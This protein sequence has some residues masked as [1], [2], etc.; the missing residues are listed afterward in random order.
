MKPVKTDNAVMNTY[1]IGTAEFTSLTNDAGGNCLFLSIAQLIE[2]E[3][4]REQS[5]TLI[6]SNVVTHLAAIRLSTPTPAREP[7]SNGALNMSQY[8]GD[9][10]PM[11]RNT[12]IEYLQRAL[13]FHRMAWE[14]E[15]YVSL[16]AYQKGMAISG[17][18]GDFISLALLSHLYQKRIHVLV[19][20]P[21]TSYVLEVQNT[22]TPQGQDWYLVNYANA[23]F[24]ALILKS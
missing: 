20:L 14:E 1:Q 11:E 17:V 13:E 12:F 19:I 16:D 2:H 8:S 4:A 21:D 9:T 6:R 10:P 3:Y 15:Y 22:P 7:I 5:H 18:Y 24:E 23:H